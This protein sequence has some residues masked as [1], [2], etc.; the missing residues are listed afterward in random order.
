MI[1]PHICTN[2]IITVLRSEC[3]L[4]LFLFASTALNRLEI[5]WEIFH[6]LI[7]IIFFSHFSN[8]CDVSM[9]AGCF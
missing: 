3:F 1:K 4:S 8:M 6:K 5:K 9:Q 7:R 2:E